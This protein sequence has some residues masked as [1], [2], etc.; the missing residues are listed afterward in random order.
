MPRHH[1][2]PMVRHPLDDALTLAVKLVGFRK[3]M[4]NRYLKQFMY[5]P[6]IM[7]V[8]L[9]G[10]I[11]QSGSAGVNASLVSNGITWRAVR[12]GTGGNSIT[13]A[14]VAGGTAGSEVVTVSSS[15]ISV[16][17][18]S[19]VSTRNQVVAAVQ[20]S[21][22]A[23]ALVSISASSGGTAA[24]L[25]AATALASG[26]ATSFSSTLKNA[27]VVQI[28]TGLYEIQL[29]DKYTSLLS[30]NISLQKAAATDLITQIQSVDVSSNKLIVFRVQAAA[31]NTNLASGD[32]MYLNLVLRN[33]SN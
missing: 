14:V 9:L 19:G 33:S 26:A 17:V 8:M 21:A 13:V 15:A 30:I 5:S 28:D 6:E 10:A 32:I 4:A 2:F 7:P 29:Q 24:S 23:S 25:L 22:A 18:E 11:T 20:A 27:S 31:T 1:G 12:M 3:F 16:Q